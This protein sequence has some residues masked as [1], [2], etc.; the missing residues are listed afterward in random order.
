MQNKNMDTYSAVSTYLYFS[1][2]KY[3]IYCSDEEEKLWVWSYQDTDMFM[4]LEEEVCSYYVCCNSY[5]LNVWRG[6]WNFLSFSFC[7]NFP[8][9]FEGSIPSG[10][11]KVSSNT[12]WTREQCQTICSNGNTC[13]LYAV[14]NSYITAGSLVIQG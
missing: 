11:N 3:L 1:S 13:M 6:L 9:G 5:I 4:D 12:Y 10:A 7:V 8:C 2:P 14:F